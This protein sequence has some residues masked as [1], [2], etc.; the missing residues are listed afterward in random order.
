MPLEKW[1][2]K[3]VWEKKG[4]SFKLQMLRQ[5]CK[6]ISIRKHDGSQTKRK[7]RENNEIY[8][9]LHIQSHTHTYTHTMICN[10]LCQ[11]YFISS[12]SPTL[13]HSHPYIHIHID[14]NA[15]LIGETETC[16]LYKNTCCSCDNLVGIHI[17]PLLDRLLDV[18]L[19]LRWC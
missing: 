11:C 9:Q 17:T 10:E 6:L 5:K 12:L 2:R 1:V 13:Q 4:N 15:L 18:S 14:A 7:T 8:F 16:T 19:P 3:I